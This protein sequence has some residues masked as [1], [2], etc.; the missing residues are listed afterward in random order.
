[1]VLDEQLFLVNHCL[2]YQ[3]AQTLCQAKGGVE[4]NDL[5]GGIK[6]LAWFHFNCRCAF[7]LILPYHFQQH[8]LEELGWFPFALKVEG[9]CKWPSLTLWKCV[10]EGT[11]Q[12]IPLAPTVVEVNEIP[13]EV[14]CLIR[15]EGL[16]PIYEAG[17]FISFVKY[18][19]AVIYQS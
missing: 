12:F 8:F 7:V 5:L 10:E 3:I 18:S 15:L 6:V 4:D 14:H 11:N 2:A 16:C 17:H 1:V 19:K 13:W 9:S